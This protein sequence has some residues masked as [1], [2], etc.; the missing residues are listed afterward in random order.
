M[1]TE[2]NLTVDDIASRLNFT[3]RNH[4]SKTFLKKTGKTPSA[5]RKSNTF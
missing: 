5:Y 4:F 1:L 3:D 2:T